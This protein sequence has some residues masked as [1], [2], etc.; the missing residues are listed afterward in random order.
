MGLSLVVPAAK[1]LET[2]FHPDLLVLRK[3]AFE[4]GFTSD[5]DFKE[6]VCE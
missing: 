6:P 2:L 4:R 1:I 3:E 5:L